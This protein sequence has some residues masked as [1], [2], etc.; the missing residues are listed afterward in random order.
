M[1]QEDV[2]DFWLMVALLGAATPFLFWLA[3]RNLSRAWRIED[4]PTAKIRSAAQGPVELD[5]WGKAMGG[6]PI[7]SPLTGATCLWWS[8]KIVHGRGKSRRV[9]EKGT[10]DGLFFLYDDTGR[11]VVN[12]EGA[13]V[14][15][16]VR[17]R[18]RGSSSTPMGGP[19]TGTWFGHYEYTEEL[20]QAD[21]PLYALGWFETRGGG[22]NTADINRGTAEL[23][24]RWKRDQRWLTGKFDR[25]RDGTLDLQEWEAARA[26]ARRITEAAV[27]EI[28]TPE[29]DL[30]MRPPG[31]HLF[32]LSAI[33]PQKLT[34][35]YKRFA[36]LSLLGFLA[37]G[38][39]L[40]SLLVTGHPGPVINGVLQFLHAFF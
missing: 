20:L 5:G 29:V 7:R 23:L 28:E 31:S 21:A 37:C 12:P 13:D 19:Q 36:A 14:V 32:L 16:A 18:W 4:T 2:A 27:R 22:R 38:A 6:L 33:P 40:T 8:Y 17:H 3:F 26:E 30:L 34:R 9:I 15:P 39:L 35:R 10:S 24:R 25:N 1:M 11:C